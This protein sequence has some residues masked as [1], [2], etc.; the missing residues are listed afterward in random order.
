MEFNRTR[1]DFSGRDILRDANLYAFLAVEII[2]TIILI[3]DP[4][5]SIP[6][7]IAV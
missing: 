6:I 5:H 2:N 4:K 3:V 1:N 7:L